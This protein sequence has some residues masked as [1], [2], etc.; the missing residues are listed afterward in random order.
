MKIIFMHSLEGILQ[1]IHDNDKIY[2]V[3][4]IRYHNTV[5]VNNKL[6]KK[7]FKVGKSKLLLFIK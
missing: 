6:I 4:R 2:N 3:K 7:K 1:E 5:C